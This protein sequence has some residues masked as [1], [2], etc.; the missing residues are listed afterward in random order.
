[1]AC[2]LSGT[3]LAQDT[4]ENA[5]WSPLKSAKA[6]EPDTHLTQFS[7]AEA[8]LKETLAEEGY[9]TIT[10]PSPNGDLH[11]FLLSDAQIMPES[12][13]AK[14]PDI[15]AFSGVSITNPALS[16][17]FTITPSGVSAMFEAEVNEQ[18]RRV[19]VDPIR[20]TENTYRSY[21]M[22]PV[23]KGQ[24][25]FGYKK[26]APKIFNVNRDL[27]RDTIKARKTSAPDTPQEQIT[28]RLAMTAAGEYTAFHGGS[29]ASAMSEIVIMVNRL[30]ALF[31][32]ELGV[33]FQLIANNDL[34]IFTD[35]A[36][37]P[38]NNDSDDGDINQVETDNRIGN[39]NYDIGHIVNTNGGG[40]AV[41]GSLCWDGFKA[42]GI[43]GSSQPTN[44]AFWID[45][46]AHEIGHQ[47]GANHTFNAAS[48]S[49]GGGN[50]ES[51]AAY[52][53][54]A[55]TT[56]M[57]YAGICSGQNI[58]FQVDD[59]YHVHSL[60]EMVS[61]IEDNRIFTPNCG[62]RTPMGNTQP[63]A[64]AGADITIPAN[65][66]FVLT[67]TGTDQN[68]SDTLSFSWEQYDLGP[69]S[70]SQLDDETDEGSGPLFRS[71]APTASPS[72]FFPQKINALQRTTAYG[73][74]MATTNR[75][76]NFQFTVRDN[77]GGSASDAMRVTVVDTGAPFQVT[78]PTRNDVITS[79]PLTVMWDVAG[80]D[81]TPINCSSVN[82]EL[83]NNTGGSYDVIL[84]SGVANNGSA[85]VNLPQTD[86]EQRFQNIRVMCANNVFYST[87]LGVFSSDIDGPAPI[88]ITGQNSLSTAEDTS[89]T[90]TIADFTFSQTPS[91]LSVLPGTNY[92]VEDN[93]VTP[94]ANFN[95]T[96]SVNVSA[97][98]NNT[99]S[100]T[101][102]ANVSVLAVNDAPIANDDSSTVEQDSNTNNID[103]ISNDTD[104]DINDVISVV[105]AT[106]NGTGTVT[107]ASNTI[108]YTPA[109]GFNSTETITYSITDGTETATGTLTVTVVAPVPNIP[110]VP[111]NDTATTIT[112]NSI[113][114]AVLTNDSDADNDSLSIASVSTSGSGTVSIQGSSIRYVSAS[115]FTGTEVITYEVSDGAATTSATLTVSVTA[116]P[117]P[118]PT[119]PASS[120]GSSGGSVS[121]FAL[122]AMVLIATR[123][124]PP[125]TY[126]A[127]SKTRN[128]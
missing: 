1:M 107:L 54:G 37:D 115:G 108:V 84:A 99:N 63:T 41:L 94:S 106:A 67:G 72:R 89:L 123:R 77:Q 90:L 68:T 43:T 34:L 70:V 61:T 122:L 10:V 91:T 2:A 97:T 103:V 78:S 113:T 25:Q 55:G 85:A 56:I 112:G 12:L 30:N 124:Y 31:A 28:Y 7:L 119:P 50:R 128:K 47:F 40:L 101:F 82:I 26:H 75:T 120:G 93:T 69:A 88:S 81:Q 46:V 13:A 126:L 35:P 96:L 125:F 86:G 16:G 8:Q 79:N 58:T 53:V 18:V 21:V 19:F 9:R 110:P 73:E 105:S 57:S 74:A 80:T 39:A 3:S 44:D 22:T 118:T 38:F 121:W 117:A 114:I 109:A 23:T 33:Q 60:N 45:F 98:A 51:S 42:N 59:Y 83:S 95:G 14:F 11:T 15:K 62:V 24:A 4:A 71:L 5:V 32:N 20:D 127:K 52:E 27:N 102:N 116:P 92:T 111:E 64:D 104:V 87:S 17:R 6:I 65:T 76:M 100:A 48:G 49:C 36:T 66:P 29:V